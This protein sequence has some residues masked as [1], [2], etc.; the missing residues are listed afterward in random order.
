LTKD[1]R[2][3]IIT[4][5]IY[6]GICLALGILTLLAWDNQYAHVPGPP[7]IIAALV[8]IGGAFLLL[9]NLLLFIKAFNRDREKGSMLV[10]AL[11][12]GSTCI[13]IAVLIKR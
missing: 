7:F 13:F 8:I 6:Y 4:A 10:H 5:S 12:L 2:K 3:G 9:I 11:I 1:F